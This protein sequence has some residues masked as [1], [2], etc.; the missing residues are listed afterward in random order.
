[1]KI[2]ISELARLVNGTV[3]GDSSRSVEK[4]APIEEADSSSLSF[5][6][7]SK[8]HHYLYTTEAAAV[9]VSNDF[10]PEK[11]TDVVLIHVEDVYSTLSSLLEKFTASDIR[12]T[13]IEQP[14]FISPS[15]KI[16][17]DVYIG[18][19]AYIGDNAVIGDRAMIYPQT[20]VGDDSKV[21]DDTVIFS[22]VKIY[23]STE[24]GKSCI[25]H[26]G[27]VIG[28]DGFGFA[29]QE[30][31]SYKKIP[32][33]GKV[34]IH[35]RVE[36]GANTTVDRATI[37]ATI[38]E[39]GVKLDNL[40]QVA[41]NV[42]IGAHTAIAAQAGIS[43]STKIGKHVAIGGQV[44]IVGH[45]TIADGSQIG[46]Q[47]GVSKTIAEKNQKWF[48]SPAINFKNAIKAQLLFKKLPELYDRILS[49][50]KALF[51][52]NVREKDE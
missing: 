4:F 7:N 19:F 35:D 18:A 50:E 30:D 25:L 16:G 40:I 39:E 31:G 9:L 8:Y 15:A 5:I 45:I 36:I 2:S 48:G 34:I 21:G 32:Q 38:I 28:S 22:G 26:S 3:E 37:K 13:G 43:G 44:G 41:H 17:Q 10:V 46:A 33:T 42:E 11:P 51:K 20:Y 24:I 23:P 47:S 27:C 14:S 52:L 12:K 6:S 1:M 49:L 29:P